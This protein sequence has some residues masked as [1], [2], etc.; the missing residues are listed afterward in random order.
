MLACDFD[1]NFTFI[2]CS[3]E[4]SATDARVLRSAMLGGFHVSEGKIS[5]LMEATQTHHAFLLLTVV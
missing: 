4:E 1:L 5:L 2:S 3:W